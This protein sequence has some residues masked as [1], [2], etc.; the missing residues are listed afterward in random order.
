MSY[1]LA[2]WTVRR[3]DLPD[4]LPDPATWAAHE[5][6]LATGR[7]GWQVVVTGPH[8]VAA[9][10]V[11]D[12]VA[13]ALPGIAFLTELSVEPIAAP[14]SALELAQKAARSIGRAAHG[15]V[16]D[17]Q[18]GT[19]TT[20]SGVKRFVAAGRPDR[21]SVIDM[22][23]WFTEGPLLQPAGVDSLLELLRTQLPEALPKRYGLY[24][25]PQHHLD[26][27]G[28]DHFRDFLVEHITEIVVWYPSRPV[29][30]VSINPEPEWG[31]GRMGFRCGY[32]AIM[33]EHAALS[34]PG[35]QAG[36][37]SFWK[38][39]SEIVE[40]FYGE[41]RTLGGLL[42]S[43]GSYGV[44]MQT[45]ESPVRGPFWRG[46]PR[47]PGHACVCGSAY[48]DRWPRFADQA[49]INGSLG[50]VSGEAW[51]SADDVINRVGPVPEAIAQIHTPAWTQDPSHGGWVKNWNTEYPSDWPFADPPSAADR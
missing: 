31:Y 18:E 39:A 45:E 50:F 1:D 38:R 6:T 5:G 33:V 26:E 36:L 16:V 15:L 22:R 35:W 2:V 3:P 9:E 14:R 37:L 8:R 48:L 12:D 40:P 20:P 29:V 4:S 30:G 42:R 28:F 51:D 43:G 32:V 24:E 13:Q 47:N 11:P 7:R 34:Q 10:D 41:V 25:P 27:A 19:V 44:D 49:T 46:V 21:F 23:W 17:Q